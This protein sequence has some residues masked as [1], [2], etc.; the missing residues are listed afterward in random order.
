VTRVWAKSS[1]AATALAIGRRL[2]QPSN[3]LRIDAAANAAEARS[4]RRASL[5]AW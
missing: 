5:R 4:G 3:G 2:A 1:Q